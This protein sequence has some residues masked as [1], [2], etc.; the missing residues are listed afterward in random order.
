MVEKVTAINEQVGLLKDRKEHV[1]DNP[2]ITS[3]CEM[4]RFVAISKQMGALEEH[5]RQLLDCS[6]PN[7]MYVHQERI[8]ERTRNSV[9]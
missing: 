2:M 3:R 7:T 6:F 1:F 5:K 4:E 9:V 8:S